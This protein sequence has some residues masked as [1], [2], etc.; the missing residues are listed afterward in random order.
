MK[1]TYIKMWA[2]SLA[3]LS[4]IGIK[5]YAPEPNT[6]NADN[7]NNAI[8]AALEAKAERAKLRFTNKKNLELMSMLTLLADRPKELAMF[9]DVMKSAADAN[10]LRLNENLSDEEFNNQANAMAEKMQGF[11]KL[12]KTVRANSIIEESLKNSPLVPLDENGLYEGEIPFLLGIIEAA[13][14]EQ[15]RRLQDAL[16]NTARFRKVLR[17]ISAVYSSL[18][19]NMSPTM[20]KNLG[21]YMKNN[22]AQS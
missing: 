15:E 20:R 13:E 1:K 12:L 6:D 21:E 10:Q 22:D 17:E 4:P 2:L 14:A 9:A 16:N 7:T 5:G 18:M 19:V 3:V 8:N 11:F